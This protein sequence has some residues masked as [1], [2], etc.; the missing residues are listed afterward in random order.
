MK[1]TDLV[2]SANEKLQVKT[3]CQVKWGKRIHP[4][5]LAAVG[6][7][8]LYVLVGVLWFLSVHN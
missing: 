1:C 3:P 5:V 7:P 4:V 8:A 2:G 6:K